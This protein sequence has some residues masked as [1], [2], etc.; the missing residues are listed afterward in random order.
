M[1]I[2]EV[3]GAGALS[4]WLK[5]AGVF[6]DSRQDRFLR[7]A[8]FVW[9]TSDEIGRAFDAVEEALRTGAHRAFRAEAGGP[10]T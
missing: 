3:E 7:L 10:V 2:V 5:T 1:V 6:T 4:E 9:N 8:P